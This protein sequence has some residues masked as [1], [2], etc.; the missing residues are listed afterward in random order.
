MHICI[1]WTI[2]I[3]FWI[4]LDLMKRYLR[5][6]NFLSVFVEDFGHEFKKETAAAQAMIITK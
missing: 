2:E 6:I 3:H 4:S 1:I 5:Q